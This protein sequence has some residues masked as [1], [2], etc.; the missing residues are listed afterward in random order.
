MKYQRYVFCQGKIRYMRSVAVSVLGVLGVILCGVFFLSRWGGV[1]LRL[2]CGFAS[3]RKQD[4]GPLY[5]IHKFILH[6]K[7]NMGI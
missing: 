6:L 5:P 3:V 2:G 7:I 4:K 1:G